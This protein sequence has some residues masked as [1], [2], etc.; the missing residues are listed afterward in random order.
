[1]RQSQGAGWA[2]TR[3][4][5]AE[6][7][8]GYAF[9]ENLIVGSA[10]A[11]AG[12]PAFPTPVQEAI[13]GYDGQISFPAVPL[14]SQYKLPELMTRASASEMANGL[15]AQP[16]RTRGQREIGRKGSLPFSCVLRHCADGGLVQHL[17][18]WTEGDRSPLGHDENLVDA[19]Q[20][21]RAMG[22]DDDNRAGTT[23]GDDRVRQCCLA[24][25]IEIGIRLIE[26]EQ[27]WLTIERPRQPDALALAGRQD[28]AGSADSGI[29]S[30]RHR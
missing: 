9:T 22:N 11:P 8:F 4:G 5:Y 6:F 28:G 19:R 23:C 17:V 2:A 7:S 16:P 20:R 27:E 15:G 24:R 14:F 3:A 12:A 18:S 30:I 21:T 26:N 10:P 29:V 13:L 1:M 25:S